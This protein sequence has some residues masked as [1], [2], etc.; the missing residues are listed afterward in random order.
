MAKMVNKQTAGI[1]S[2][3]IGALLIGAGIMFLT[4]GFAETGI[5]LAASLF[6]IVIGGV[7]ALAGIFA[8]MKNNG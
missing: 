5:G 3:V 4:S 7:F 8:L 6:V 1:S 2:L